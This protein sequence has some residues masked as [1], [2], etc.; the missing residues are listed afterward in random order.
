MLSL[1]SLSEADN[2]PCRSLRLRRGCRGT[3]L[4]KEGGAEC[5]ENGGKAELS[6]K[7][8]PPEKQALFCVCSGLTFSSSLA[9]LSSSGTGR[10]HLSMA[11]SILLASAPPP[12]C[13]CCSSS[14]RPLAAAAAPTART[15]RAHSGSGSKSRRQRTRPCSVAAAASNSSSSPSSSSYLRPSTQGI[16]RDAS[17]LFGDTPMV[18]EQGE[19]A[20]GLGRK[21][22]EARDSGRLSDTFCFFKPTSRPRPR[23][24]TL[25]PPLPQR[26]SAHKTQ[27]YLNR[28]AEG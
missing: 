20:K 3:S 21:E 28:L 18:L 16:K 11:S 24:L 5:R 26:N 23:P 6:K 1:L 12:P 9:L 13:C 8:T 10:R 19:R 22:R 27:V 15:P 17:E 25:S 14:G 7:N 4:C 2:E